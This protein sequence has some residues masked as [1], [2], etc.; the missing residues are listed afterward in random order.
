MPYQWYGVIKA[1]VMEISL[2]GTA[3]TILCHG[4]LSCAMWCP[5]IIYF[6]P[7]VKILGN[8]EQ[9]RPRSNSDTSTLDLAMPGTV[10]TKYK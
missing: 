9:K 3:L 6:M 4:I 1:N 5:G 2:M 10:H 7:Y 8:A